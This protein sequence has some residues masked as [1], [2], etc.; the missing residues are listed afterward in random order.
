MAERLEYTHSIPLV[1]LEDTTTPA[2]GSISGA[3]P[4]RRTTTTPSL[5]WA[6]NPT[7]EPIPMAVV[8]PVGKDDPEKKRGESTTRKK[9]PKG[10]TPPLADH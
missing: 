4:I 8:L 3:E 7:V 10:N 9:T 5:K 6:P 1:D 2:A